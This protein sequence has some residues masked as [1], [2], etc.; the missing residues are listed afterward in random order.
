MPQWPYRM[1][2]ALRPYIDSCVGYDYRLDPA[3][4]HHGVPSMSLTVIIAFDE[5]LDCGWLEGDGRDRFTTLVAGLHTRPSLIRTHGRQHGIQLGLTPLGC[6]A[7]LGAPAAAFAGELVPGDDERRLPS[8]LQ[9]R[10][11]EATWP[12][13]FALLEA[14][15][16][17][18]I[19]AVEPRAETARAWHVLRGSHGSVRVETLADDVGLSRRRLLT[20]VR[21]EFGL[22]PSQ[23]ARVAR[24]EHARELL[25][26]GIGLAEVAARAGYADQPHLT[27]EWR[28]ISGMTPRASLDDFPILQD[29]A[30]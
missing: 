6:R 28:T 15:L 23:L 30:G 19:E 27:R 1:P 21:D 24:F 8:S 3:A 20:L 2:T 7:L 16:L 4:T 10:L 29:D 5:P 14:Y 18:R 12:R 17:S 22:T 13:R 11:Q 25:R 9:A 26:S